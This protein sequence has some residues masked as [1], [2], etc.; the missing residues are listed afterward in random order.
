LV[1]KGIA[2]GT[3]AAQ[4]IGEPGTQLTMRTFHT[5]GIAGVDDITQ[6]LP[7]VEE[8]FEARSPKR[9]AF[10]ADVAGEI[11]IESA[12]REIED[13]KGRII[14]SNPQVKLLKIKYKGLSN[15]KYSI[16]EMTKELRVKAKKEKK[17][18]KID[19]KILVKDD[20]IVKAGDELFSVYGLKIKAEKGGKIKIDKKII[21]V[22]HKALKIKEFIVPKGVGIIVKEGDQ[23][24]VGD[25]LTD[26]SLDLQQLYTL[27]DKLSTQKYIIKEIQDVYSSQGQPLN[28]K[29]VEIIARQMFS[30]SFI[31]DAGGTDLLPGEIVEESVVAR[32]EKASAKKAK[33]N[34]LLLGITKASLTTDSFLSAASFQETAR[35]LIEASVNGKIDYL[36][37]LKENM[38]I[39]RLIPAGT[40]YKGNKER[41]KY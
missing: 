21:K 38:I 2:V 32:S 20:D 34:K 22:E 33:V 27:R 19:L 14:V 8:I 26:G 41:K 4:S 7:R 15:D 31:I 13:E 39:G 17:G 37:G 10:M 24:K 30:R 36:E 29:H 3:I 5:G 23:V 6:G 28:D 16:T 1:K 25:Q 9:K 40:G 35:V 11:F 18:V 12:Q